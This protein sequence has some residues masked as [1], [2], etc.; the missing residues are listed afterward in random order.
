MRN[1]EREPLALRDLR[2]NLGEWIVEDLIRKSKV[3]YP[4]LQ[5]YCLQEATVSN[6]EKGYISFLPA[7][8]EIPGEIS[9]ATGIVGLSIL[10][11][12]TADPIGIVGIPDSGKYL[13]TAI[14]T[15]APLFGLKTT[16][17]AS[18]SDGRVP[19]SWNNIVTFRSARSF[20]TETKGVDF[21]IQGLLGKGEEA[22]V[23]D[24]FCATG[25]TAASGLLALQENGINVRG[26]ITL[27][28][29]T[30]QGGIRAVHERCG[31]P[32]AAILSVEEIDR[33]GIRSLR[34]GIHK[35]G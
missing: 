5:R 20:T 15:V 32:C 21:A 31:V 13:A 12:F 26:F 22:M 18:R 19:G 17:Y 24:D 14:N 4:V 30:F 33:S 10:R 9:A 29:K 16:L 8:K 1:L 35:L 2:E 7:N 23:V 11:Q 28:E 34:E 25:E 27:V 6:A 3:C